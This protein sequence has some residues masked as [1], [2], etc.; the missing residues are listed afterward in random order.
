MASDRRATGLAPLGEFG[1]FDGSDLGG[2]GEFGYSL[3]NPKVRDHVVDKLLDQVVDRLSDKEKAALGI[4]YGFE[5]LEDYV[6]AK[7]FERKPG[8]TDPE[9]D[10]AYEA[11]VLRVMNLQQ[12]QAPGALLPAVIRDDGRVEARGEVMTAQD[13]FRPYTKP[14]G[15]QETAQEWANRVVN[16]GDLDPEA[17]AFLGSYL[18]PAGTSVRVGG[19]ARD[20]YYNPS[21]ADERDL[22]WPELARMEAGERRMGEYA[23]TGA[24]LATTLVGTAGAC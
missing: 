2:L 19:N 15:A 14:D 24:E 16:Q 10:A 1:E 18:Y 21:F 11:E 9:Y 13:W 17:V 22:T 5:G 4:P 6:Q 3:E 8:M 20:A 12:Q 23:I 7:V